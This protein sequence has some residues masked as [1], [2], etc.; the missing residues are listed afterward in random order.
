MTIFTRLMTMIRQV[1]GRMIPYRNIESVERVETPL[2]TDMTN[3]LNL[4]YELY[5]DQA[6]W[7]E[8]GKVKSMNLPAMISSEVARQIVLEMKWNITGKGADGKTTDESGADV[9]NPRSEY[10]KA[11]FD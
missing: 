6:W 7:L 1:L 5:R 10:L 4:W 3:A 8:K 11:E 2:S 9:T